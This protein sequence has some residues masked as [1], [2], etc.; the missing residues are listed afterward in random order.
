M[1][2]NFNF[3]RFGQPI[4]SPDQTQIWAYWGKDNSFEGE[5]YYFNTLSDLLDSEYHEDTPKGRVKY[6]YFINDLRYWVASDSCIQR[7]FAD[8]HH[9]ITPGIT[10]P[11]SVANAITT[12]LAD[13]DFAKFFGEFEGQGGESVVQKLEH[14]KQFNLN[15]AAKPM[16]LNR[17]LLR[18]KD[19]GLKKRKPHQMLS[20]LT[21]DARPK[22]SL[23]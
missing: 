7:D 19:N 13:P 8:C 11:E 10:G 23:F 21:S 1:M 16:S 20:K 2:S 22:K 12:L 4:L 9:F 5:K 18:R 3:T 6:V 14:Y 15:K 17:K